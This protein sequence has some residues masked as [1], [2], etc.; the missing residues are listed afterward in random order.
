MEALHAS[1][2]AKWILEEKLTMPQFRVLV[3]ATRPRWPS[4]KGGGP[5]PVTAGG[6]ARHLR[7]SPPTV[8]GIVDRLHEAGLVARVRSAI[9]RRVVEVTPTDKG[10]QLVAEATAAQEER[11]RRLFSLMAE[12]DAQ[13]LLRG[14]EGFRAAI[15]NEGPAEKPDTEGKP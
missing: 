13:A 6:L 11:L 12:D 15:P 2:E 3:L 4:D 7:L 10:R 1:R 14:L 5:G 8:T 9:D